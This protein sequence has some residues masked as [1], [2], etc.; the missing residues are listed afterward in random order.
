M[1]FDVGFVLSGV[2]FLLGVLSFVAVDVSSA[3]P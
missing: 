3:T 2:S 1:G